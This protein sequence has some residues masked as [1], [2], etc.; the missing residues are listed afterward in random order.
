[1]TDK[2]G[3]FDPEG[4]S[5]NPLT[6]SDYS[7]GYKTL[8]KVWSSF[9]AYQKGHEI[10]KS[11]KNHQI[12][13]II[14]STG[15]GKTVL[16]PKFAL[17]YTDYKGKIAI[18]LPKRVVTKSA[19]S[20]AAL[21]LDVELGQQVGFIHKGSPK[22]M[23]SD[24]NRL[25]YM[26][27]G[28][29]I[30]K[31]IQDPNLS[32]FNVI[33]IDEAH[34][35]KVQID[36]ILLF[37]RN[38]VKS[39]NRPD[40]RVVIM[41]ATIDGEKYKKYFSGASSQ[42]IHLSGQTNHEIT[43]IFL[44]KP[45]NSFI[46]TGTSMI[47][48]LIKTRK[49]DDILFFITTSKEAL[50]LCRNIRP[51][52]SYVYCIEVYAE[53]DQDLK[54]YVESRDK[55]LELGNFD[56]RLIIATNVAE[57]SLTIDGLKFV[58]DS[59]YELHS[60]FD[61]HVCGKVFEKRLISKAQALQRRG[62]VG[63]TEPGTCYHL[64][65]RQQFDNLRPYPDPDILTQ[66][67]TMDLLKIIQFTPSKNFKDGNDL[68]NQLMDPPK[69]SFIDVAHQILKI[70]KILDSQDTLTEIAYNITKFS[71]IAL[72][73]IL[74]LIYSYQLHC[75][76]DAS[77]ILAMLD[78]SKGKI[79]NIFYRLDNICKSDFKNPNAIKLLEIEKNGDHFAFLKIFEM[80]RDSEDK[81]EWA[82]NYGVKLNLM[83]DVQRKARQYYSKILGLL[84]TVPKLS[85][86]QNFDNR[87]LLKKALQMSHQ[88]LTAKNMKPEFSTQN[89]S[90]QIS[91]DSIIYCHHKRKDL[92]NKKFIYDEI[93][94]INNTW[95]FNIITLI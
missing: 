57:S 3:I 1:M 59:G 10:L 64:L 88:H 23:I 43:T 13:F 91:K 33:I 62:R 58:I 32:E 71:S 21:T 16:I 76:K 51:K 15:S 65:T 39:G 30:M 70:Y 69:K 56:Q 95:E 72:N 38:L 31:F 20:F 74:F 53:M 4:K 94:N 55:F 46:T 11:I 12:T 81:R 78:G 49:G 60:Y 35:R 36:L 6:G 82:N 63:R 34:E 47:E 79:K 77:N 85:R 84:S 42:I 68:L 50:Q 45:T 41:S 18:T 8:G 25:V 44:E 93:V 29:L 48:N 90:G 27:D 19:A 92:Q 61:P 89:I 67:I 73:R 22:S 80:F 37:L 24:E 28:V 40:L 26:T 86:V 7:P 87:K 52:Y 14:S 17:H 54:I 9:P 2:I 5:P 66:D 83:Y 75:A